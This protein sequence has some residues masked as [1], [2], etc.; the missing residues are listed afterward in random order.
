M[1][2][3]S[4]SYV[5][6]GKTIALTRRTFVSKVVSFL[7]Y[8]KPMRVVSIRILLKCTHVSWKKHWYVIA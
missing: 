3:F 2:Q 4:H 8:L 1:V 6:T 5:T 7:V